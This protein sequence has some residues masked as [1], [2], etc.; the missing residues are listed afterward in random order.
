MKRELQYFQVGAAYGGDQERI[1]DRLLRLGGCAAVTAC[2]SCIYFD[3]YKGTQGLYPRDKE[4]ISEADYMDFAMVM[5]PYL[6]PRITGI[7]R[8]EIYMEGLGRYLADR[9]CPQ[10]GMTPFS[11]HQELDAARAAVVR[12]IEDGFPIPCL[13]LKHRDPELDDYA[14]H[15]FLLTGY[16][17]AD[18]RFLVK[19]VTYGEWVW[20]DL[21]RLWDTGYERR[22]GLILYHF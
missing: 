13:M 2:D 15:W 12:Q 3:L 7:D 22:G 18:G 16:E 1:P 14:W 10:I 5:K 4:Q 19:V 9:G 8:L 21:A 11:G 17:E 6:H 20:M